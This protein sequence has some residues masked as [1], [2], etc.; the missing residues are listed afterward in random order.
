MNN[1]HDFGPHRFHRVS[2]LLRLDDATPRRF[3]LRH[4][5][6]AAVRN[7]GK[8][9]AEVTV[10]AHDHVVPRLDQV[11]KTKLHPCAA[12]AAYG[13]SH[14]VFGHEDLAQHAL[15]LLHHAYE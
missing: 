13:K 12:R 14:V 9:R 3:D 4:A 2:D 11:H 15:D 8:T 5:C 6:A 10:D 1:R 7:F